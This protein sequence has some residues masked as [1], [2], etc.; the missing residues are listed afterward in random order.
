MRVTQSLSLSLQV[1]HFPGTPDCFIFI[2][3]SLHFTDL[4]FSFNFFINTLFVFYF[5]LL[6]QIKIREYTDENKNHVQTSISHSTLHQS[7]W[8]TFSQYKDKGGRNQGN[9]LQSKVLSMSA[10]S[11]EV[12]FPCLEY[13]TTE[14]QD[15]F[16]LQDQL[17]AKCCGSCTSLK[18]DLN[19]QEYS[20]AECYA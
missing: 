12:K 5:I 19:A 11:G 10:V 17:G 3:P 16:Y 13:R 14:C 7:F 20:E 18:K 15:K 1:I 6:L 2:L 8:K 9:G 4:F